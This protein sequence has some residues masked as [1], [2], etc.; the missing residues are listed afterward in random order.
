MLLT[1][2]CLWIRRHMEHISV[3]ALLSLRA[4]R[5]SWKDHFKAISLGAWSQDQM[6]GLTH[7]DLRRS[8]SAT[9]PG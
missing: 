4:Q 5:C 3:S 6:A 1:A 2:R 9:G 7:L 8:S